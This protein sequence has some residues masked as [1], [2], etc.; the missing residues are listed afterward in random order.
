MTASDKA[1]AAVTSVVNKVMG[2]SPKYHFVDFATPCTDGAV[3]TLPTLPADASNEDCER[4]V[5]STIAS[6][7]HECLHLKHT[8]FGVTRQQAEGRFWFQLLN[9]IEDARINRIGK[10]TVVSFAFWR[11]RLNDL[12]STFPWRTNPQ[13]VSIVDSLTHSVFF[14]SCQLL[15]VTFLSQEQQAREESYVADHEARFPKELIA[16]SC[17]ILAEKLP[18]ATSTAHA[19]LIASDLL[20]L[21]KR[22]CE[23]DVDLGSKL[24]RHLA[25]AQADCDKVMQAV[26]EKLDCGEG[27]GS[28][29]GFSGTLSEKPE[30]RS[31]EVSNNRQ[32]ELREQ[33]LTEDA[34]KESPIPLSP[35]YRREW[36]KQCNEQLAPLRRQMRKI[37]SVKTVNDDS[38]ELAT[39]GTDLVGMLDWASTRS[40]RIYAR[41]AKSR[42][43][44][45]EVCVILDRSGSMGIVTMSTAKLATFAL[46]ESIDKLRGCSSEVLA[47]PGTQNFHVG[48]CKTRNDSLSKVRSV[49]EGLNAYGA[50]PFQ[51][52]FAIGL[53]HLKASSKKLKLALM[54][55]D[56][57]VNA[58]FAQTTREAY[59]KEG[60]EIAVLS[61]GIDNQDAFPTNYKF[62]LKADQIISGLC[63]LLSQTNFRK[64]LVN[65]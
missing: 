27:E 49:F 39:E 32:P 13:Q 17:K 57:R 19:A 47:F 64:T 10:E 12:L 24:E 15:D 52:A 28:G 14:R 54:I 11:R 55:T 51:E 38:Y 37:F 7:L 61:I 26:V 31:K 6:G 1:K 35:E 60:I 8:D 5:R 3:I 48:I 63:E 22:T 9:S 2:M 18:N 29:S 44:D 23:D 43:L 21:L 59:A 45:A 42:Q 58:Q 34:L 65:S 53:Q 33:K 56:G 41:A 4:Y 50:T 62:V 16:E 36:K 30:G 46:C 40:T 25:Q 20:S